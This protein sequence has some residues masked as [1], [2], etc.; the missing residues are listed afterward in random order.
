MKN[1]IVYPLC[2]TGLVIL[3]VVNG[4]VREKIYGPSMSELS[5]HQLSTL[6][7]L[8]LFGAYTYIL[9]GIARLESAAQALLIGAIWVIMTIAFEFVFGHFAMGHSWDRLFQDYNF[10]KGRLWVVVLI[11]TYISPYAFFKIRS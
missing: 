7:G 11:W 2:W 4:A 3:A 9:T 6:T 5:A 8:I 1:I 10:L